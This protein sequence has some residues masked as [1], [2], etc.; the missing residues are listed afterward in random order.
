MLIFFNRGVSIL[1]LL[2]GS[3]PFSGPMY[4]QSPE[5]AVR[6][7]HGAA[8][9]RGVIGGES[10]DIYVIHVKNGQTL[11]VKVNWRRSGDNHAD[12]EL[13]RSPDFS[14]EPVKFGKTTGDGSRFSGRVPA[15]GDYFISVTGYPTVHY[16]LRVKVT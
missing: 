3:A 16:R 12:F 11:S 13:S 2:I 6:R 5:P 10:H 7:L 14:G 15:T 8:S 4:S 9:V 1:V